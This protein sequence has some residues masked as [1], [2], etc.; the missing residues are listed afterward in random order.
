VVLTPIVIGRELWRLVK[1]HPEMAKGGEL[2]KL[3]TPGLVGMVCA[4]VAGYLALKLLSALLESGRWKMFGY[5][6]IAASL[7]VFGLAFSGY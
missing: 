7:V 5:Y 3:L 6:C 1:A 2:T 4:F